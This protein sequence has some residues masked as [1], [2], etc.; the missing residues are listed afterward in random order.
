MSKSLSKAVSLHLEGKL[1]DAMYE[2]RRTIDSGERHP[3]A[4]GHVQYEVQDYAAAVKKRYAQLLN[5]SRGIA[6]DISIWLRAWGKT[7]FAPGQAAASFEKA[8]EI[9]SRRSGSV[10]GPRTC[11]S[12]LSSAGSP[13]CLQL[14]PAAFKYPDHEEASL[15]GKAVALQLTRSAEFYQKVIAKNP[16]SEEGSIPAEKKDFQEA[17]KCAE[18]L[19]E[20][21]PESQ[22][23]MEAVATAAF[24]NGD[25]LTAVSHCKSLVELSPDSFENW[26]NL[27]VAYQRLG[28]YQNAATAYH[29]A[30]AIKP[31]SAQVHLN[32]GV[33]L[34]RK[35]AI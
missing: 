15:F 32:L 34:P 25:L 20:I 27:G 22:A 26:F 14:R 2:L 9:D 6:P 18:A 3:A 16:K 30:A 10:S 31:A 17:R 29:K 24:A 21:N 1:D 19:L 28:N 35:S 23:A 12:I 13:G 8:L 33:S 7:G 5:S 4:L 11:R